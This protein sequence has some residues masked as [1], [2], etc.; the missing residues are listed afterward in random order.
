[1]SVGLKQFLRDLLPKKYQVAIKYWNDWLRGT[2]EEE[3]K[4]LELIVRRNDSVV[5]V[6]GNRGTYSYQL[7]RLGARV[8]VFEPNPVC[9]NILS[10]WA[11]GKSAVHVHNVALSKCSG[12]ANLHIPIDGSGIEHDAS[13]SIES[14]GFLHARDQMVSLQTLDSFQ[15]ENVRL[16]KIDVEGH[17]FSVIEG[18][19]RTITLS[20]P[21]LLVE[22]EQRHLNGPISVVFD[23]ILAHGYCGFFMVGGKLI[24]LEK[25]EVARHQPMENFGGSKS[26]YIN[27]FLFLHQERLANGEYISLFKAPL[28]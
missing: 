23:K 6:G 7:W 9:S 4:L 13:A 28:K 8:E 11:V 1:M 27:N 16:I 14:T 5:D 2:L 3:M 24:T 17:E 20:W 21:V 19:E 22:I 18:A 26:G 15:F 25:F 10:A 12:N